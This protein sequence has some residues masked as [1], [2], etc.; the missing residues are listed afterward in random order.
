MH[1]QAGNMRLRSFGGVSSLP[2]APHSL[3]IQVVL[4]APPPRLAHHSSVRLQ[5]RRAVQCSAASTLAPS[6]QAAVTA[7]GVAWYRHQTSLG[8]DVQVDSTA[9][10]MHGH[11][12]MPRLQV[13]TWLQQA[14]HP[15]HHRNHAVLQLVSTVERRGS[16]FVATITLPAEAA[17]ADSNPQL[18]WCKVSDLCIPPICCL[19]CLCSARA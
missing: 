4:P 3:P 7:P 19:H 10:R 5:H 17:P 15:V 13:K 8:S 12:V 18:Q 11:C 2:V 14:C 16:N 6:R 9:D 1:A